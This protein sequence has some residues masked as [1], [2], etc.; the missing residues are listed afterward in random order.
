MK[1][2]A[3]S[4]WPGSAV[5]TTFVGQV[6]TGGV[7]SR[8]VT[9]KVAVLVTPKASTATQVTVLVPSGKVLPEGGV[10][11]TG[12]SGWQTLVAVTLKVATAPLGPVASITWLVA[13]RMVG[14]LASGTSGGNR[15]VNL[16]AIHHRDQL[17]AIRRRGDGPTNSGCSSRGVQFMPESVEV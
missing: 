7:V 5:T 3:A 12:T 4:H 17:G 6:R 8:T 11:V 1:L 15:G 9:V 2:T 14:G 16:A 13:P 10:Q